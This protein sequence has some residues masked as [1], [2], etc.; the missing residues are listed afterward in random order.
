[1]GSDEGKGRSNVAEKAGCEVDDM[2]FFDSAK[3][4]EICIELTG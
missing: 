3:R 1:M 4:T 2:N